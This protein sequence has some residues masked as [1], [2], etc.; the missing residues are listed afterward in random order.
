MSWA[1]ILITV[2]A[3][4]CVIQM[5]CPSAWGPRAVHGLL[6]CAEDLRVKTG[7]GLCSGGANGQ[8]GGS[9]AHLCHEVVQQG[10]GEKQGSRQRGGRLP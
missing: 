4:E 1:S 6:D 3:C 5:L 8:K 2:Q 9:A 10:C 7:Q